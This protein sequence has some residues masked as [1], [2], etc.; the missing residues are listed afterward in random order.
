LD[1]QDEFEGSLEAAIE[2]V[3]DRAERVLTR[4]E[5]MQVANH[6]WNLGIA[7]SSEERAI[8]I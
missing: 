8:C 2:M 7:R 5:R 6:L 3:L 1:Y 4:L